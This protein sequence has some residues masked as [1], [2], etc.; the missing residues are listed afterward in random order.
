MAGAMMKTSIVQRN[1]KTDEEVSTVSVSKAA[2]ASGIR[3]TVTERIA[4]I[5]RTAFFKHYKL[6]QLLIIC[7]VCLR[8][9]R[10]MSNYI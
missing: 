10:Q 8:R 5:P 4:T 2:D 7:L 1:M 9:S 3:K 6:D